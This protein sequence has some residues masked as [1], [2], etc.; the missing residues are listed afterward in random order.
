[1]ANEKVGSEVTSDRF[2]GDDPQKITLRANAVGQSDAIAVGLDNSQYGDVDQGFI[3]DLEGGND[4]IRAF[5]T[6]G[7]LSDGGVTLGAGVLHNQGGVIDL[8]NGQ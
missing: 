6:A 7:T 4:L 5:G 1:M 3:L 2:E 8:G